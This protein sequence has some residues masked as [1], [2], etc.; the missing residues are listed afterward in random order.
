MK[1]AALILDRDGTLIEHVPYL[2]DP[3]EVRLLPGV[4][5][6]LQIARDAGVRL[7]MHSN[8]SGIGRGMFAMSDVVACNQR[9]I[10]LLDM[11]PA[12]FEKICT[13]PEAPDQPSVY[14]KPSPRFAQEII[15]EYALHPAAVWY[16]GD[17]GSALATAHA[18]GTCGSPIP[19]PAFFR[20]IDFSNSAPRRLRAENGWCSPMVALTCSI[21]AI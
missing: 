13:A 9:L 20:L 7:F 3:A 12:P 4:R 15:D 21:A 14:R 1:P 6:A 2:S 18:A 19:A 11:G 16:L 5:E 8:Q 17:R 10:E